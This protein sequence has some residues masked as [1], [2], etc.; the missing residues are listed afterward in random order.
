MNAPLPVTGRPQPL[1]TGVKLRG[2]EKVARI[3]VKI[4]PTEEIPRKPE[5]IRV[6]IATSPEVA[7]VKALLRKHKL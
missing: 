3:P 5:W 2:A 4:L 1:Q 7:R 6:P